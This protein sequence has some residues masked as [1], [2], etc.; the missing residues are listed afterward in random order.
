MADPQI[1]FNQ[2]LAAIKAKQNEEA[3]KLL[4]EVVRANPRHELAWLALASV[5]TDMT[6]A[7]ECLK[8][9]LAINPNNATA[10]E[11]LAFAEKELARQAAVP[12]VEAQAAAPSLEEIVLEE[13]GDEERP[14]PRLGK[15]LMDYKFITEAQLKLALLFQRRATEASRPRRLGDILLEQNALTEE[16]L[17]F[18]IREQHRNFYSMFNDD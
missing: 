13:P 15:F 10:Q 7:V 2:A 6:K 14:V 12:S 9:V 17:A 18:A 11:W 1:L 16:R 5:L 4:T 8:R 3:Q